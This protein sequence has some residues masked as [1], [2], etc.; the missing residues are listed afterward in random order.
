MLFFYIR[1]GAPIYDPD[2][3]TKQGEKQADALAK[4]LALYGIDRIFSS[5]SNRAVLT[6]KPTSYLTGK[7]IQE[8]D[9]ANEV[10][11]W[12][13]WTVKK[14]GV[15]KWGF[16]DPETR[17]LFTHGSVLSLGPNWYEHE[18]LTGFKKG[19]ERIANET[20]AFFEELGYRHIKGEGRY[21]VIK[22]NNE[23]VALF[24]HQG[25]GIAFLSEVLDIPYPIFASHFD[26]GHT[27]MTVIQFNEQNGYAIPK[28][29]TLSSDS[30]IYREGLPTKYNNELYF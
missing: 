16:Q 12:E 23:R 27:G 25:F 19:A 4:R 10:H 15:K 14:D 17:N 6:A 11:A 28:V 20:T 21:E 9:F 22:S 26:I 30:H 24:A 7:K 18:G 5:P 8:V 3:L 29:L 1:H 2:S 13:E